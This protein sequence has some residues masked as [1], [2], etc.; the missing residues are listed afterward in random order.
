[1]Y[2]TNVTGAVS[3]PSMWSRS[4]ETG[5]ANLASI[6]LAISSLLFRQVFQR[7][8]NPVGPRIH[9]NWRNVA[10]TDL[11]VA[12]NDKKRTLRDTFPFAIHTVC[13]RHFT[14]RLEIR[15]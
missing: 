5:R 7:R 10:P 12:V 4:F 11:T 9:I 1:P 6:L 13:A 8:E 2:S 15:E 3:G 14:F